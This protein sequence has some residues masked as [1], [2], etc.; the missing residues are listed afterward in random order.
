VSYDRARKYL[1]G[2]SKSKKARLLA[3]KNKL[4]DEQ[5]AKYKSMIESWLEKKRG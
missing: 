2:L 1:K 3:L 4:T 5:K